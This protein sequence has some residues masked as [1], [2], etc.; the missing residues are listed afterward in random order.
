MKTHRSFTAESDSIRHKINVSRESGYKLFGF[1]FTNIDQLL[2]ERITSK[3]NLTKNSI[4]TR[5]KYT[6][7]INIATTDGATLQSSYIHL[8][9]RLT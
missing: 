6:M 8:F 9:R 7:I 1:C 2:G 4:G 3:I 5:Y